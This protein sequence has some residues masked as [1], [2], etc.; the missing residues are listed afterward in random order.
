MITSSLSS[1][2]ISLIYLVGRLST[3]TIEQI[4]KQGKTP[5]ERR[6]LAAQALM[7]MS[8]HKRL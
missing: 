3:S 1:D 5:K 8:N 2:L 7:E 6:V 4:N